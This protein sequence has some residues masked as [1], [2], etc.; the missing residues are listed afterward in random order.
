MST[1][2]QVVVLAH[3]DAFP[4]GSWEYTAM[5][6]GHPFDLCD[7]DFAFF[8]A[9]VL[10]RRENVW[11]RGPGA[12]GRAREVARLLAEEYCANGWILEYER[13]L[14]VEFSEV[15]GSVWHL[16]LGGRS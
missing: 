15:D 13:I 8:Y 5:V 6:V 1:D 3:R 9:K 11:F 16:T 10:A 2:N 12:S 4:D 7:P 14:F